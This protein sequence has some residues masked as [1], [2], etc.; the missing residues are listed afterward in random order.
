MATPV[1]IQRLQARIK[2]RASQ[3]I[4][5]ELKDPRLGFLTLTKVKLTRDL[6]FATIYYSILG[7]DAER[8]RTQKALEH[9]RGFIQREVAK[10][11]HTRIVPTIQFSF[12]ESVEGSIRISR[13]LDEL[14]SERAENEP[15]GDDSKAEEEDS[16]EE[17][18]EEHDEDDD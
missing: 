11:L 10:V 8:S 6:S 15:E 9:A 2:E 17:D 3:V 1:R 13:L 14:Q 4:L 7:N 12:D 5:H 16:D 18:E